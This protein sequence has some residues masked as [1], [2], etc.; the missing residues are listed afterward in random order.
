MKDDKV[1]VYSTN[2]AY[3]IELLKEY[4]ADHS[5]ASFI[6]N[7]Q[8]SSYLFGDIELYVN[9]DDVIQAKRLISIFES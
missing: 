9:S 5:I 6:I 2:K 1:L 4:L 8:D 7:K 3:Q